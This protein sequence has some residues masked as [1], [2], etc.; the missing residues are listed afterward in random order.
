M[1]SYIQ[2][3]LSAIDRCN[4]IFRTDFT[5]NDGKELCSKTFSISSRC[6]DCDSSRQLSN[7]QGLKPVATT[8]F[9]FTPKK[10]TQKSFFL[11]KKLTFTWCDD[12]SMQSDFQHYSFHQS[13]RKFSTGL[14]NLTNIFVFI[15]SV[16]LVF[17][18]AHGDPLRNRN[19]N[20]LARPRL[21]NST[22]STPSI[23]NENAPILLRSVSSSL[24]SSDT[25]ATVNHEGVSS[26]PET[27]TSGRRRK[28][29]GG[30]TK[31]KK[32]NKKRKRS[33]KI[34]QRKIRKSESNIMQPSL[35]S[36][37]MIKSGGKNRKSL[38]VPRRDRL[39]N[40]IGNSF[41][42]AVTKK[43]VMGE[44]AQKKSKFSECNVS[45]IFI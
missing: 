14:S 2:N 16:L 38:T 34:K 17:T 39:Y 1:D 5:Q 10:Q 13:F 29:T 20:S 7:D 28:P 19:N 45:F 12:P 31:R 22:L 15:F 24:F 21:V 27:R 8:S 42:L 36:K 23:T 4:L 30:K 26:A 9:T 41:H 6:S 33:K 35:P 37:L 44:P 40:K 43:G 3:E 25:V 11:K 32:K 18:P